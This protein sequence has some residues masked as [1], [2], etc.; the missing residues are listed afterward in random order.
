MQKP[1]LAAI[2]LGLIPFAAVC[3]SVSLWD[4]VYPFVFGVILVRVLDLWH[5]GAPVPTL[6]G[7][8]PVASNQAMTSLWRRGRR[9][10]A[11]RHP[12]S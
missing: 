7:L 11:A 2:L 8:G 1:S 9:R 5:G 10:P 12:A 4:R 3:F 6:E